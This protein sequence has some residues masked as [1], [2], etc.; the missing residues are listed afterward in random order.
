METDFLI[1][2]YLT[3]QSINL[4]FEVFISFLDVLPLKNLPLF[5]AYFCS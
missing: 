4:F 2:E 1:L 3:A 5:L